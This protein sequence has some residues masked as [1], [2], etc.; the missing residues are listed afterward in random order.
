MLQ[1]DPIQNAGAGRPAARS[2]AEPQPIRA[3]TRFDNGARLGATEDERR[4]PADAR[5][6]RT[7][8]PCFMAFQASS[9]GHG[10][11]PIEVAWSLEDG[12]IES[13]LIDPS[14]VPEWTDWDAAIERD[15]DARSREMLRVHGCSP[16]AVAPRLNEVLAGRTL[17]CDG[18]QFDRW[19]R[20]RLF[21]AAG[22]GPTFSLADADDL[23][24]YYLAPGP[25]AALARQAS[26]LFGK[27]HRA[28]L[29]V[30]YLQALWGLIAEESDGA[31]PAAR[32]AL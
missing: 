27:R 13:W 10:S 26:R 12:R 31:L 3:G 17:Y 25:L 20:H 24:A 29:E 8:L 30:G 11:Y 5:R 22:T 21:Q 2:C 6:G 23:F 9:R 28:A 4:S 32:L 1:R 15:H 14:E 7:A 19:W 18:G 16:R